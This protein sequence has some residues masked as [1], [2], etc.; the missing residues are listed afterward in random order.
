MNFL[1][2]LAIQVV[3]A[4][5]ASRLNKQ[6]SPDPASI[7]DINLPTVS[8]DRKIPWLVG[9]GKI[10]GPNIMNAG[11]LRSKRIRKRSGLFGKKQTIGHRYYM[12]QELGLVWGSAE[13][14]EIWFGD[15]TF[16]T[17]TQASQADIY[18]LKQELYGDKDVE[19]GVGGNMTFYPGTSSGVIDA[20]MESRFGT[21]QPGYP[22][23]MRLLLKDFYFGNRETFRAISIVAAAYPNPFN[24]SNHI[25]NGDA[26]PAYVLYMLNVDNRFGLDIRG[27]ISVPAIQAM[28]A[29][30]YTEGLGISR[31]WYQSAASG[32]GNNPIEREILS[33]I[34]GVRYRD[35][36]TGEIIY[37]LIRDDYDVGSIPTLTEANIGDINIPGSGLSSAATEVSLTYIDRDAGFKRKELTLPNMAVRHQLGRRVAVSREFL[38][39]SNNAT[40]QKVLA[41]EALHVSRPLKS[42]KVVADRTAWDWLPGSVFKLQHAPRGITQMICRLVNIHRGDIK[43]GAVTIDF[44]EEVFSFG[45]AVYDL[46]PSGPPTPLANAPADVTVFKAIEMPVFLIGS[47]SPHKIGLLAD[48]PTGDSLDF[49]L[50]VNPGGG[51]HEDDSAASFAQSYTLNASAAKLATTLVVNGE[52]DAESY[53][54]SQLLQN[55]YNMAM[56]TTAGG[57]AFIAFTAATYDVNTDKTTLSGVIHGLIDT[58]PQAMTAGDRLW[59]LDDLVSFSDK[60][61]GTES[62]TFR[63]LTRT[64]KGRLSEGSA[65]PRNITLQ[66]RYN[67]PLL[68]GNIRLNGQLFPANVTG[69]LAASW[70]HRDRSQ[71]AATLVDWLDSG[72]QGPEAGTTYNVNLYNHTTS[73]LLDSQTGVT[74]TTYNYSNPGL[75]ATLRLEVKAVNGAL[76]SRETYVHVFAYTQA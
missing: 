37:K 3:M 60:F 58:L 11:N 16:W 6:D 49:L 2:Q 22:H 41:R 64:G 25:I 65:T 59:L 40:A 52:I 5:I 35:P 17:G 61:A 29:Q 71:Q 62:V 38:G 36:L 67:K 20:Y 21:N 76:I 48:P 68:P 43:D 63:M 73:A 24:A 28:A 31:V 23:L 56:V 51:Y 19:G 1:I 15:F 32:D 50:Q 18:S 14:R 66:G 45:S 46:V 44:V 47:D 57:D 34:E 33:L 12:D 27:S 75:N 8:Q 9:I 54:S 72:N 42:G 53:S 26:N 13:L 30:L 70:N 55:G 10:T 4:Y 39:I 74:G 7:E 69:P